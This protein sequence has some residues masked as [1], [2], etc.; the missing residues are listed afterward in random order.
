MRNTRVK[1]TPY[2]SCRR[3]DIID[4]PLY[5]APVDHNIVFCN[6][7]AADEAETL[8][9]IIRADNDEALEGEPLLFP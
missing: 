4:Y 3:A 9:E 6:F 1:F 5:P 7:H 8:D 2:E